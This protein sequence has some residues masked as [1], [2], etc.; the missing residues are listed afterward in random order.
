MTNEI[1]M[2]QEERRR[3]ERF[4]KR[5]TIFYRGFEDIAK[6]KRAQRG[7]LLDFS[8]GGARFLAN[9]ELEKNS[10]VIIELDFTGWIEEGDEWIQ[11]GDPADVSKLKAIG[12]IMWCTKD[13]SEPDKYEV[14]VRF[15]GR[16]R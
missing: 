10:Q 6:D 16:I 4:H 1:A 11:T 9:Q 5:S 3:H 7:T 15:T 13:E 14:G 8:G 12:A 2:L